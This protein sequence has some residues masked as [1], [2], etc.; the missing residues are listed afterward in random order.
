MHAPSSESFQ[1]QSA[2]FVHAKATDKYNKK[3]QLQEVRERC[4]KLDEV[5][6]PRITAF[7]I[8]AYEWSRENNNKKKSATFELQIAAI[9][10][11]HHATFSGS[12]TPAQVCCSRDTVQAELF[13]FPRCITRAFNKRR[14]DTLG[15][16]ARSDLSD[17][18]EFLYVFS[19]TAQIRV[20]IDRKINQRCGKKGSGRR[21][22]WREGWTVNNGW[23]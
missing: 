7:N 17:K 3:S 11:V 21:R 22:P 8:I 5:D 4:G 19:A 18:S 20:E 10:R 23:K 13:I 2:D 16:L 9:V 14:V 15:S 1:K 12:I 6:V